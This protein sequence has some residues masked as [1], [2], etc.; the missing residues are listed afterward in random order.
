MPGLA[1]MPVRISKAFTFYF[2]AITN[3]DP[4]RSAADQLNDVGY[5]PDSLRGIL[6]THAHWDHVGGIPDFNK[7][8]VWINKDEYEFVNN[9]NQLTALFVA[10]QTFNI[11]NMRL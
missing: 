1:A 11:N 2:G 10:F 6:L 4:G 8:P 7:T 3:F 9:G 5:N